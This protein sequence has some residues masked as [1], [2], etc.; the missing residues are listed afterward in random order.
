MG[1]DDFR[2]FDEA[3]IAVLSEA[4]ELDLIGYLEGG[5]TFRVTG[6]TSANSRARGIRLT[7]VRYPPRVLPVITGALWFKLDVEGS[8][9]LWQEI[10]AGSK[11][12]VDYAADLIPVLDASFFITI[13]DTK[14][15][16]GNG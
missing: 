16:A 15:E 7:A 9:R 11:V 10:R 5:D 6:V 12:V 1:A 4:N 2:G 3:Y 14:K 8:P 13:S